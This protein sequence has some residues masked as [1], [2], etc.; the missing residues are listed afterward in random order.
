M[1]CHSNKTT[2]LAETVKTPKKDYESKS[3]LESLWKVVVYNDPVNLMSYVTRV[4]RKVLGF[5]KE[6]ATKHM[7]EVHEQGLSIVWIGSREQ[8]EHYTFQLQTWLLKA[9]LEKEEGSA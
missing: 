8:A 7:M 4:F 2:Y 9:Q 3:S 5:N 6:K 1:I